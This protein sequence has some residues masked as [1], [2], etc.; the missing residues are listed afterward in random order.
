MAINMHNF[1]FSKNVDG[2]LATWKNGTK[3]AVATHSLS[4]REHIKL[5]LLK[6]GVRILYYATL[7]TTH[8]TSGQLWL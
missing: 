8:A 1:E 4:E 7:H 6:Q 3:K 2:N 5:V